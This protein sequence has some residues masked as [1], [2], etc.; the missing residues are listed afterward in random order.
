MNNLEKLFLFLALFLNGMDTMFETVETV[1]FPKKDTE[2][3]NYGVDDSSIVGTAGTIE[4]VL[5]PT[6][7]D[8]HW[9]WVFEILQGHQNVVVL[10][11]DF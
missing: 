7:P 8:L 4:Q 1:D 9:N 3:A 11:A 2:V 6:N 5:V 10:E